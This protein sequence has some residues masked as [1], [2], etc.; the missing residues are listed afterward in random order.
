MKR[1]L[2]SILLLLITATAFGGWELRRD[3]TLRY[4]PLDPFTPLV[5][6]YGDPCLGEAVQVFNNSEYYVRMFPHYD[7]ATVCRYSPSHKHWVVVSKKTGTGRSLKYFP[8]DPNEVQTALAGAACLGEVV[9]DDKWGRKWVRMEVGGVLAGVCAPI[10]AAP[11]PGPVPAPIVSKT[12]TITYVQDAANNPPASA[13]GLYWST[14]GSAYTMTTYALGDI[15]FVIPG[16]PAT[17]TYYLT[18]VRGVEESAASTIN[19][20]TLP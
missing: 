7:L 11:L 5:A 4:Y 18:S 8:F 14:N 1:L 12:V 9:A 19:T 20:I 17:Y 15:A 16:T 2:A 6:A 10:V 3:Q 13:T